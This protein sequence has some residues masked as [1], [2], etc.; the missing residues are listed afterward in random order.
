MAGAF[1]AVDL[2]YFVSNLVKIQEGGWFPLLLGIAVFLVLTTW[3]QGRTLLH[4][5]LAESGIELATLLDHLPSADEAHRVAGTSVFL[6]TTPERVPHALLHNL[7][8]NKVLHERVVIVT[9]EVLDVPRVPPAQRVAVER[10]PHE[11]WRVKVYFGFMDEP[12]L[13]SAL[14][15]CAEQGLHL[16]MM[17]TSFFLGRETLIPKLGSRM[18]PWREKLFIA[19]Y[20]NAGSASSYFNLPPNRVVELGAQVVL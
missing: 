14:E 9:V 16:E 12:D 19:L 5:T 18:T 15:W 2:V 3:K 8:H 6:T 10:L 13:P 11:F 4:E 1:L 20:R 7:K 17:Q